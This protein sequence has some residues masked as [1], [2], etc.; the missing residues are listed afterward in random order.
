[1]HGQG[2]GDV[3]IGASPFIDIRMQRT[4]KNVCRRRSSV[5]RSA[6]PKLTGGTKASAPEVIDDGLGIGGAPSPTGGS[7]SS[8]THAAT[9]W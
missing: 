5:S 3:G 6:T 4:G 2:H 7:T 8:A 9:S 1:V